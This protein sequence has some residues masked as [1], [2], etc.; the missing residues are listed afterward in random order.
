MKNSKVLLLFGW[1][2]FLVVQSCTKDKYDPVVLNNQC[3]TTYYARE[4]KPII[5][6]NCSISG[7]HNGEQSS[8][9]YNNYEELKE[10]I[11][12]KINNEPELLYR[13]K[14]PISDPLHM[15]IDFQLDQTDIEKIESWINSGYAGC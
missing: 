8:P 11:E 15:P 9:N 12:E 3:D 10:E 1:M 2:L 7:C 5:S 14:L 4:I 6:K 13:L